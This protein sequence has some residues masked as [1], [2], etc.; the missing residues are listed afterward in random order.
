MVSGHGYEDM[1]LVLSCHFCCIFPQVVALCIVF[2]FSVGYGTGHDGYC[3]C[4]AAEHSD[5]Y[6]TVV[7]VISK[8]DSPVF[9]EVMDE[10]FLVPLIL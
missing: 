10:L 2:R 3:Q 1:C 5:K 9:L 8:D 4:H 7:V 6:V